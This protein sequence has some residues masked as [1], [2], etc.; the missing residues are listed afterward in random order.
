MRGLF[1][2][3]NEIEDETQGINRK[4]CAQIKNFNENGLKCK[5]YVLESRVGKGYKVRYRLP[6]ANMTPVWKYNKIFEKVDFIYFRRPF[7]MS[8]AMRRVLRRIKDSNPNIKIILELPTYPYD[9][10][11][12]ERA[13]NYPLYL[14][15]L[16]NR[17]RLKG[18]VDRIATL[19]DDKKIWGIDTLRI[20]NGVDLS[21]FDK[22]S[23]T[24]ETDEIH[25][26]A[27][28][29]FA[30]W[31]GYERIIEG[32]KDYYLKK[33]DRKVY[34]HLVGD[35]SETAKYKN[36]VDQFGLQ[37]YI[38]FYGFLKG[39]ELSKIYDK[40]DIAVSSLGAHKIDISVLCALK[41]REYVAKGMPVI[42][43]VK[44]DLFMDEPD[45]KYFLEF[46]SDDTNIDI[47]K[48]V[49]FYDSIY[50]EE[51]KESIINSIRSFAERKISIE[52]AMREVVDYI[53]K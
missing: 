51:S 47:S 17:K 21:K 40:C 6:F 5:P 1:V 34:L 37:E 36:L 48:I 27:V 23:Y 45:Y 28:A 52:S 41:S 50:K 18:L 30:I 20:S 12:T 2:I 16:Y 35:C 26:I 38:K 10:E 24:D 15:D 46:P 33:P 49:T 7:Q 11:I 13:V 42:S 4:I 3:Y 9:K 19:T 44:I 25:L 39:E 32:L 22:K 29:V 8:L 43:G 14:K 53:K 31:H